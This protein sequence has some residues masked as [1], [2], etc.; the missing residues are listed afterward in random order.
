MGRAS[1]RRAICNVYVLHDRSTRLLELNESNGTRP[2][3]A[4]TCNNKNDF[5]SVR[6]GWY[7]IL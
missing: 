5:I 7:D 6:W 1:Q 3:G 2:V 4:K